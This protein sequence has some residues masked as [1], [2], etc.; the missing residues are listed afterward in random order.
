MSSDPPTTPGAMRRRPVT[1]PRQSASV[2]LLR[3]AAAGPE[4]LLV[5][6]SPAQRFMG[7][8]W[9]FPGGA[10]D[11]G[12]GPADESH[13][14]AAVREL[15]E[16]AGVTVAAADLVAFSRWI[17]PEDS[18]IRFDTRFYLARAPAGARP[19]ADGVE[20]VALRW[21]T[22]RAALGEHAAG[23]LQLAF[24]TRRHLEE[25]SAYGSVDRLLGH[26]RTRDVQ[27]VRPRSLTDGGRVHLPGETD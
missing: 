15:R 7:G 20:C 11:A 25:L 17:T 5:R 4:L 13:V 14:A 18:E 12:D 26:A 23:R 8:Y 27:P 6:R 24:P 2:I 21:S 9:V 16:E 3:D 22:A 10:V 19:R 1:T